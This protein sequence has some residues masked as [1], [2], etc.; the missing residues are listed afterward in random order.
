MTLVPASCRVFNLPFLVSSVSD[1]MSTSNVDSKIEAECFN[2]ESKETVNETICLRRS[3][4]A[5]H[6]G[7][8]K[9]SYMH[10]MFRF[11][12]GIRLNIS[13]NTIFFSQINLTV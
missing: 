1:V 13:S 9:T 4:A 12:T 3:F 5:I 8:E 11:A 10:D 7:V 2:A 6:A